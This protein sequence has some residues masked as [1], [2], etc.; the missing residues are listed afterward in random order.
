MKT[1]YFERFSIDMTMTQAL[2]ASHQGQCDSDV[3]T[4]LEASP[5][6]EQLDKISPD[7]I[8]EELKEYGAWHETELHDDNENRLRIVW[9]AACDIR[10]SEGENS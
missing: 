2:S 3:V 5:I 6:K 10:E 4:L 7:S 9:I 1:A 8:R